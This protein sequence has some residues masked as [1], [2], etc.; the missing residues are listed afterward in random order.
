MRKTFSVFLLASLILLPLVRVA[1]AADD[2]QKFF[3]SN[4]GKFVTLQITPI[5]SAAL[6]KVSDARFFS[7]NV[8]VNGG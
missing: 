2:D 5:T 7:I 3:D 8:V 1:S 6:P 4:I